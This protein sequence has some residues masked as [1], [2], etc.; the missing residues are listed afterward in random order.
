MNYSHYKTLIETRKTAL[1]EEDAHASSDTAAVELDQT[2]VGRVSRMDAIQMQ[3]MNLE[4]E[5]RRKR[6]LVALD[7]ALKRIEDGSYGLCAECD[8]DI[9][10]KRLEVDPV[11]VHCITC[12]SRLEA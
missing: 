11:A 10:P 3:E 9:N 5:R 1:L 8:E 2:R 4:T 7:N 12:A 6:E